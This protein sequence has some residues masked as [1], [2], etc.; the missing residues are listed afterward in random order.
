M[1]PWSIFHRQIWSRAAF[2]LFNRRTFSTSTSELFQA[3]HVLGVDIDATEEDIRAAFRIKARE[4]TVL[5]NL[6]LP[7]NLKYARI[8][9]KIY[10]AWENSRF[11]AHHRHCSCTQ[12]LTRLIYPSRRPKSGLRYTCCLAYSEMYHSHC[13][14]IIKELLSAFEAIQ[15]NNFK[16]QPKQ[17]RR[18]TRFIAANPSPEFPP[19]EPLT[20]REAVGLLS[21]NEVTTHS[22]W[23]TSFLHCPVVSTKLIPMPRARERACGHVQHTCNWHFQLDFLTWNK[24]L[25][26]VSSFCRL[27]EKQR[28]GICKVK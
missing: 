20:I 21:A 18:Q 3:L 28:A 16:T 2:T 22:T 15:D 5:L 14:S 27:F 10:Q 25:P 23:A 11:F 4:Y 7:L 12:T 6:T 24:T 8:Q 13:S 9:R 1:R 26:K 19:P 17:E